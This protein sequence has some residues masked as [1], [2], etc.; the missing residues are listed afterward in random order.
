M[1]WGRTD[2]TDSDRFNIIYHSDG[3]L[4]FDYRSSDGT[5]HSLA[6]GSDVLLPSETW[7]HLTVTREGNL[8]KF[9]VNG[10]LVHE[11][12]DATPDLPTSTGWSMSGR[13]GY[14]YMGALDEVAFYNRALSVAEIE[15]LVT[16]GP[17]TEDLAL[18]SYYSFDDGTAVDASANE[19]D[20]AVNGADLVTEEGAESVFALQSGDIEDGEVTTIEKVITLRE[21]GT[22]SFDWKISSD[23]TTYTVR[24]DLEDVDAGEGTMI[25]GGEEVKLWDTEPDKSFRSSGDA[26]FNL[27]PNEQETYIHT[28]VL[29]YDDYYM[30]LDSAGHIDTNTDLSWSKSE[31][32]SMGLFV[33]PLNTTYGSIAGKRSWE[34]EFFIEN[35]ELRFYYW[36]TGGT[37]S[38]DVRTALTAGEWAHIM[39]VYDSAQQIA[40]LYKN[41]VEVDTDSSIDGTWQDRSENLVLGDGYKYANGFDGEIDDLSVWNK[42]LTQAEVQDMIDNSLKGDETDLI[43]YY[44]FYDAEAEDMSGHQGMG[45]IDGATPVDENAVITAVYTS[46]VQKPAGFVVKTGNITDGQTTTL[47]KTITLEGQSDIEFLW[48]ASTEEDKDIF[49]FSINGS[50]FTSISGETAWSMVSTTLA[51]GTYTLNWTYAKDGANSAG[52][53]A[54]WLDELRIIRR[55]E[56]VVLEDFTGGEAEGWSRLEVGYH[57]DL[58]MYVLGGNNN[59]Y[60][61]FN[62]TVDWVEKTYSDI[63]AGT[64]SIAFDYLCSNIWES[65]DYAYLDVNGQRIWTEYDDA[66]YEQSGY[67]YGSSYNTYLKH[68]EVSFEHEGGDLTL[69]FG[70]EP[71]STGE[72]WGV[73]NVEL[74][75]DVVTE[76]QLF[77]P[78]GGV[79]QITLNGSPVMAKDLSGVD[80]LLT[81]GLTLK[82]TSEG[83]LE[84]D[85]DV[86]ALE[87]P[88]IVAL[89]NGV[90]TDFYGTTFTLGE[91]DIMVVDPFMPE[92]YN[93]YHVSS[94]RDMFFM[95]PDT[96]YSGG[97]AVQ[98]GEIMDNESTVIERAVTLDADGEIRYYWKV[99]SESAPVYEIAGELMD[100]D[101][102]TG[103][104]TI[105]GEQIKFWDP[106]IPDGFQT[107]GD[108]EFGMET[109][110]TAADEVVGL[111]D[112]L[113]FDGTGD[114][115]ATGVLNGSTRTLAAWVKMEPSMNSTK[116]I[117]GSQN[118]VAF[119]I[120]NTGPYVVLE[121]STWYPSY[122]FEHGEWVHVALAFDSSSARFYV[123]G[124]LQDTLSSYTQSNVDATPYMI[125]NRP[126]ATGTD[127]KGSIDEAA[128]IDRMLTEVEVQN[129]MDKDLTGL[130]D[131]LLG[132]YPF[133]EGSVLDGSGNGNDG[134]IYGSPKVSSHYTS[135]V[136]NIFAVESGDVSDN[137]SSYVEKVI[138]LNEDG[139]IRFYW[140]VS[141]ESSI[142]EL[143]G[144][145]TDIDIFTG[146]IT[147]ANEEIS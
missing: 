118:G 98:S 44:P 121:D 103:K 145:E 134:S 21:D 36:H 136:S 18:D 110:E 75:A 59:D 82:R 90:Y 56:Q 113:H 132:Y 115:V 52:L 20:G 83:L 88:P 116:Y 50:E 143:G 58:G 63:K 64:V 45:L 97:Y 105:G 108:A 30:Q 19:K 73:S 77:D 85:E 101:Y 15:T 92:G 144:A 111:A 51:A 33:N 60:P 122:S 35:N 38:I 7:S 130:Q 28:D 72:Y 3:N 48:K 9:Y 23:Y 109:W 31:D 89:V 17:D 86:I 66:D 8:Y 147:I 46:E 4:M 62:S 96:V 24:G 139:E 41:G 1:F 127:F 22:L 100:I 71:N 131:D 117:F 53:D 112:C 99:S 81:D 25:I 125:G 129:L 11:A 26:D 68:R 106:S 141:S 54:A 5:L 133:D 43:L 114:Y 42:A 27:V 49:S 78:A 102:D 74:R 37:A 69:R 142:Y 138:T 70:G 12:T 119:G 29:E 47:E 14:P 67:W 84:V 80:C 61:L 126:G 87:T 146:K 124:V 123:N 55:Q 94:D 95:Q 76:E 32:F 120:S 140:K 91:D 16:S 40:R 6:S 128:I 2:G 57:R 93:G 39:V 79:P 107:G 13:P 104:V 135:S 65:D 10:E 137:Q 34:Y